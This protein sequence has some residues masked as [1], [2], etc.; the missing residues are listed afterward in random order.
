MLIKPCVTVYHYGRVD[1]I[2][3]YSVM[4][5]FDVGESSKIWSLCNDAR[6]D[7]EM[8]KTLTTMHAQPELVSGR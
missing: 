4:D 6:K 8:C 3:F 1:A 2:A 5:P 7:D